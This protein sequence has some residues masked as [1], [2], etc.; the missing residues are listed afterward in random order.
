MTNVWMLAA[1]WFGLALLASLCSIYLRISTA[2]AEIIVGTAAG[3]L[4]LLV[5][6][7]V[8]G[9]DAMDVM[10]QTGTPLRLFPP[11]HQP[12]VKACV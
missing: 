4:S 3:S 1:L 10:G 12:L 9:A 2:L 11:G 5:G 8:L 6:A 7:N